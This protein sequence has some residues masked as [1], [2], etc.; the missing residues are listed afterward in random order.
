METGCQ[1]E[2]SR[3]GDGEEVGVG[4]GCVDCSLM[5]VVR[6]EAEI[7]IGR[8]SRREVAA[9]DGGWRRILIDDEWS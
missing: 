5:V 4:V 8:R 2:G 3:A 9:H 7:R 6:G 1:R